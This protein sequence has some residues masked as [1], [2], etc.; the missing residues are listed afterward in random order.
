VRGGTTDA[1]M[2]HTT[3]VLLPKLCVNLESAGCADL[4]Q[5]LPLLSSP[6]ALPLPPVTP[7]HVISTEADHSQVCDPPPL[8]CIL[9]FSRI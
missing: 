7:L 2:V 6:P 9:H 4:G 1:E 8:E 5:T 3:P